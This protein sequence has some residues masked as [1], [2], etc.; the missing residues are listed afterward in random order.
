MAMRTREDEVVFP[1]AAGIDVGASSHWVA[2]PRHAAEEPVREFGPMTDD[3]NAMAD[4]LL[5][6]GVDTV[7]LESTGVYWIPVYEVLEQRGLKVWLVDARQMKYVPGRKSDVQDCQWLQKLM[8]LGLLRAAW[9]PDG[10]VCVVRAVARQREVL[11]AEQAS[12]IQ[13]VCRK[14]WCR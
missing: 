3:L 14:H 9:R 7:A 8:S 12:W 13:R 5:A 4:W 2:V 11:I 6:C 1:N 10:D